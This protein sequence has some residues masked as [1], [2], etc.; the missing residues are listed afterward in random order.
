MYVRIKDSNG[1]N[2][3]LCYYFDHNNGGLGLRLRLTKKLANS[4]TCRRSGAGR[5]PPSTSIPNNRLGL[6]PSSRLRK[7]ACLRSLSHSDYRAEVGHSP[8]QILTLSELLFHGSTHLPIREPSG[9]EKGFTSHS[10]TNASLSLILRN[11]A[12][13]SSIYLPQSKRK[14]SN[15]SFTHAPQLSHFHTSGQSRFG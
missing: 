15:V 6:I 11:K 9:S 5:S 7:S 1:E 14:C 2:D 13:L 10:S 3:G 12:S 4:L 8:L